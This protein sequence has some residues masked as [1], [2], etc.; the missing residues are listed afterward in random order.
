MEV[1]A[2]YNKEDLQDIH[3]GLHAITSE[4][5]DLYS[6]WFSIKLQSEAQ[7]YAYNG[8]LGRMKALSHCIERIFHHCPPEIETIKSDELDDT[9]IFM[10]SFIFNVFGAIDNLAHVINFEKNLNLKKY[11]IGL[12]KKFK[13]FRGNVSQDFQDKLHELDKSGWFDYCENFRHAL[14]HRIP[15]YIPPYIVTPDKVASHQEAEQKWHTA[16]SNCEPVKAE[17][18]EKEMQKLG[19]FQP[20]ITHGFNEEHKKMCFHSQVIADWRTLLE[21]SKLTLAELTF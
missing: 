2:F 21:L 3:K 16:L 20:F 19:V 17:L 13:K 15:L 10:Q 18:F 8:F 14:A 4:K 5:G 9:T 11:D 1:M 7:D 6:A 12:T